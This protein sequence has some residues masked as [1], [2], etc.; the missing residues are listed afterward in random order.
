VALL[1]ALRVVA[2]A[3]SNDPSVAA[4][5]GVLI[6]DD[7]ETTASNGFIVHNT[8]HGACGTTLLS[9]RL[10]EATLAVGSVPGAYVLVAEPSGDQGGVAEISGTGEDGIAWWMVG[11]TVEGTYPAWRKLTSAKRA[12]LGAV[13]P[14]AFAEA[15]AKAVLLTEARVPIVE[16]V[17]SADGLAVYLHGDPNGQEASGAVVE[18]VGGGVAHT[19]LVEAASLAAALG[20]A[21]RD[22]VAVGVTDRAVVL[23][24]DTFLAVLSFATEEAS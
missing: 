4:L 3:M 6:E 23:E 22:H 10:V 2:P 16:L 5:C 1:D 8:Q 17:F 14:H 7:G 20:V 24:N 11:R 12:A 13:D 21:G 15:V 18:V 9:R 19:A